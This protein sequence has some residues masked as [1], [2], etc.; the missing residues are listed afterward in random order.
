MRRGV[1]VGFNTRRDSDANE[2]EAA[3]G[4]DKIK[5]P[6]AQEGRIG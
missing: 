4:A 1:G 6:I 3:T 5:S 2:L